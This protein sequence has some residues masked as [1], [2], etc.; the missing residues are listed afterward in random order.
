[1]GGPLAVE[2]LVTTVD[3][4]DRAPDDGRV[5]V[6]A[7]HE[8]VRADG[9]RLLLLDDRGWSSSAAWTAVSAADVEETARV[10]VGPDEPAAGRTWAD[11]QADHW[12]YLARRL[13]EHG[14]DDDPGALRRLPHDV[15]LGEGLRARITRGR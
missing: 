14:Q 5:S 8:A 12:A 6:R 4:D 13:Q 7:L 3:V 1:V 10:V 9:R 11:S 2:R 15:V